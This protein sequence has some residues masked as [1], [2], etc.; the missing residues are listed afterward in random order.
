MTAMT[1]K[2]FRRFRAA[3]RQTVDG[4]DIVYPR[5]WAGEVPAE[6]AE[7]ADA[8]GATYLPEPVETPV[9]ADAAEPAQVASNEP[10]GASAATA[11]VRGGKG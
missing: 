1:E 2:T 9:A 6:V 3:H 8:A 7:A 10:A 4:R 11:P 5:G